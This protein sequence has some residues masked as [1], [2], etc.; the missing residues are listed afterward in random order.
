M[1]R[2]VFLA[3]KECPK[4]V[5]CIINS[6]KLSCGILSPSVPSQVCVRGQLENN[7]VSSLFTKVVSGNSWMSTIIDS[8]S[9]NINHETPVIFDL[10]NNKSALGVSSVINDISGYF[11]ELF[12]GILNVK[13]TFQ[14]SLLRRKRKH[15]FL[16]RVS[17]RHG[18]KIL[19]ARQRKGRKSLCA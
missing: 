5:N 14:P 13:R 8:R 18:I 4:V 15:G 2:P 9:N 17:T 12:N 6:R 16:H 10:I 3:K 1:I 7:T 19:N 11:E